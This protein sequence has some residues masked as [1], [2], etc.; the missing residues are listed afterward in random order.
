MAAPPTSVLLPTLRWTSALET[1]AAQLEPGDELLVICDTRDD[2]IA[3]R[4]DRLP[5]RTR[6][7]VAGEPETC[8][9]KAN[10]IAAGMD[11]ARH[12]RL[13]WTDDD[14]RRP[15]DWLARL[16]AAYEREGPVS[17]IPFFVGRDPLAR[18]LE[19]MY[20]LAGT[21]GVYWTDNAWGG[22]VLFERDDLEI[23]E[24]RFVAKL[25]R[26]ISDDGLLAEY[27]DVTALRQA[28]RVAVG[29]RVRETLE[30]H[31]R[32]VRIVRHHGSQ[33]PVEMGLVTVLL[34]LGCVLFPI[35]A[36]VLST[37][38]AGGTY[39]FFGVRRWTF[40]LAYPVLL[41]QTP[42]FAY[43]LTRRTFVWSGRRYRWRTKFD[44]D[45]VDH[46]DH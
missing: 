19:P 20:A 43:V 42:L 4:A 30:R 3:D 7:V 29:G 26:T 13:V 35:P 1:V 5:D 38:L 40:L 12:D 34:M 27:L 25:R 41:V 24:A 11:A 39:A 9:G 36:L 21:L 6:L 2:P 17:E 22:A 44:V 28:R 33:A 45:I 14:F 8:S 23:D 18:L 10:A 46:R 16:H 15:S 31:V 37:L 32:F